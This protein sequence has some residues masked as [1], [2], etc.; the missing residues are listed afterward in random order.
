MAKTA[1]HQHPLTRCQVDRMNRFT[2]IP[3]DLEDGNVLP[4]FLTNLPLLLLLLSL[5][6]LNGCPLLRSYSE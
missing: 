2:H 6:E 1:R 5:A 4:R 3:L